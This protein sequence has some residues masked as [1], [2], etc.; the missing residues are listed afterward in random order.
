MKRILVVEDN[1]EVAKLLEL[2]LRRAGY[3]IT[4]AGDGVEA[5]DRFQEQPPDL[6]L[7]DI[8]LPRMDGYEV[9]THIRRDFHSTIPV[10]MLSSL[11]SPLDMERSREAGATDHIAKPF[12]KDQLLDIISAY[13]A[14][15]QA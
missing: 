9:C 6:V 7:L 3:E 12:D 5:L 10:V 8:M 15:P 2:I 4:T 14:S 11:D 13:I 1:A